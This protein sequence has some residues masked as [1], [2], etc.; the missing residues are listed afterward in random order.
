MLGDSLAFRDAK[1]RQLKKDLTK[2]WYVV[3]AVY[4]F[5]TLCL[6]GFWGG[7]IWAAV[8]FIKKYW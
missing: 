5:F 4:A 8:H 2:A 3:T 6:L 1:Q 7:V